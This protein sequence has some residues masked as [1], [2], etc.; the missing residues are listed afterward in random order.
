MNHPIADL[1]NNSKVQNTLPLPSYSFLSLKNKNAFNPI[2]PTSNNSQSQK[3]MSCIPSQHT[4]LNFF[5]QE[6]PAN[7]LSLFRESLKKASILSSKSS[8][9]SSLHQRSQLSTLLRRQFTMDQPQHS[10]HMATLTPKTILSKFS[11][12]FK[13]KTPI[14]SAR[15]SRRELIKKSSF[16]L[17]NS[18]TSALTDQSCEFPFKRQS[19]KNLSRI[20]ISIEDSSPKKMSN[21]IRRKS[22]HCSDCGGLSKK[23]RNNLNLPLPF[24]RETQKTS[25]VQSWLFENPENPGFF[26]PTAAAQRRGQQKESRFKA[27]GSKTMIALKFAA[28]SSA[29]RRSQENNSLLADE[30][31]ETP[32][33]SQSMTSEW[34]KSIT[35]SSSPKKDSLDTFPSRKLQELMKPVLSHKRKT[36]FQDLHDE[37]SNQEF[38]AS[39]DLDVYD[40]NKK[41]SLTEIPMPSSKFRASFKSK[42]RQTL[43][44]NA[45][46][47]EK[48]DSDNVFDDE[49]K[50]VLPQ[51][52]NNLISSEQQNYKTPSRPKTS[53]IGPVGRKFAARSRSKTSKLQKTISIQEIYNCKPPAMTKPSTT[54]HWKTAQDD[55]LN[56]TPKATSRGKTPRTKSRN[57]VQT[58]ESMPNIEIKISLAPEFLEPPAI[59]INDDLNTLRQENHTNLHKQKSLTCIV[60]QPQNENPNPRKKSRKL[61]ASKTEL[62][63]RE[64]EVAREK[65][66]LKTSSKKGI[67]TKTF[68]LG[69]LKKI[70]KPRLDRDRSNT[71]K[72]F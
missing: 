55:G 2:T 51:S 59:M 20:P 3:R 48:I 67:A 19:T 13:E 34:R 42:T 25:I 45:S 14:A 8:A 31:I 39:I 57:F 38:T 7:N 40:T 49:Q 71:F 72:A 22:C 56:S 4:S 26:T 30:K 12:S 17:D 35:S 5:N 46:I 53:S 47:D 32:N 1:E 69:E 23:E 37:K 28:L 36:S 6:D 33:L 54:K 68:F 29:N 24:P 27:I 62:A 50:I 21:L 63:T 58:T 52:T 66:I 16:N 70:Y 9:A 18:F 15:S 11:K 43:R 44:K 41:K 64:K 61:K 60:T 65:I 10:P